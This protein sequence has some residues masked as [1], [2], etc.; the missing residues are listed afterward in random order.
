MD[1]DVDRLVQNMVKFILEGISPVDEAPDVPAEYWEKLQLTAERRITLAGYRL[2][3]LIIAAADQIT[4]Q[5]EF[6]GR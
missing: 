2:A 1:Q 5:R 6:V 4:A 3:D